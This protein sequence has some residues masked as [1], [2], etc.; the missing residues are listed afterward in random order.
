MNE[1]EKERLKEI[2]SLANKLGWVYPPNNTSYPLMQLSEV[3]KCMHAMVSEFELN[4]MRRWVDEKKKDEPP[5]YRT[6][7]G[8]GKEMPELPKDAYTAICEDCKK[9][10]IHAV[11]GSES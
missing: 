11:P 10:G 4:R 9:K 6:C 3:E 5:Q 2:M 7:E 1:Q 8:C